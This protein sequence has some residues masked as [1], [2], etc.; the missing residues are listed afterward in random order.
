M[1]A[2]QA[3]LPLQRL[4]QAPYKGKA[5]ITCIWP[6]SSGFSLLKHATE[7]IVPTTHLV[8][9]STLTITFLNPVITAGHKP[10]YLKESAPLHAAH[11]SPVLR[12]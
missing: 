1:A 7:A 5:G 2:L 9:T 4:A 3:V 10:S 8:L 11:P 6:W 12:H